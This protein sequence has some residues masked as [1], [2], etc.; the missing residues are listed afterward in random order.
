MWAGRCACVRAFVRACARAGRVRSSESVVRVSAPAGAGAGEAGV[1][2][3]SGR[4]GPRCARDD[5]RGGP[6]RAGA[7]T[8]LTI[9]GQGKLDHLPWP[10]A[11]RLANK[12]TEEEGDVFL[13]KLL[14]IYIV[15]EY[16]IYIYIYTY[17]YIHI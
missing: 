8:D 14:Y 11:T 6:S 10:R 12:S 3:L 9:Y 1:G 4:G 7:R 15:S 17:I 2:G 13:S 5:P 16:I